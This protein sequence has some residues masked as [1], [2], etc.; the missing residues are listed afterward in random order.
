MCFLSADRVCNSKTA[1]LY[2]PAPQPCVTRGAQTETMWQQ[3]YSLRSLHSSD[4]P[5][6]AESRPFLCRTQHVWWLLVQAR[7]SHVTRTLRR[8]AALPLKPMPRPNEPHACRPVCVVH[9]GAH[10]D[11]QLR[12]G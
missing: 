12:A 3:C 8:S 9:S 5:G 4:T 2:M 11:T 1:H 6:A 7:P 10:A